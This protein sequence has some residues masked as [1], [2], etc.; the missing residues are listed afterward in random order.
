M[1]DECVSVMYSFQRGITERYY[2]EIESLDGFD[3]LKYAIQWQFPSGGYSIIQSS[4][5][6]HK[7]ENCRYVR[8]I[9]HLI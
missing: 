2:T 7:H 5:F 8:T 3:S 1:Q 9:V 4:V 6:I